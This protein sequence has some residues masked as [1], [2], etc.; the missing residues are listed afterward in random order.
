MDE[1]LTRGPV[2]QELEKLAARLQAAQRRNRRYRIAI[3]QLQRAH[4]LLR[5]QY[6]TSVQHNARLLVRISEQQ[7]QL[8]DLR[9]AAPGGEM[10]N[11]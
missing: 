5:L 7:K 11:R 8:F 3:R 10:I 9:P 2:K 4:T 6:D 1:R